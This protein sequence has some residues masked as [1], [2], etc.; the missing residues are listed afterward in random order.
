MTLSIAPVPAVATM[1][2]VF[3]RLAR[4]LVAC[5]GLLTRPPRPHV[6]G[7]IHRPSLAVPLVLITMAPAVLPF[8]TRANTFLTPA[9]ILLIAILVLSILGINVAGL[10]LTMYV[11]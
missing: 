7:L 6:V 3:V 2:V 10:M 8:I 5:Y 1:A 11:S 9:A 4:A